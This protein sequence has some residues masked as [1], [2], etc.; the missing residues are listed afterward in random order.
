MNLVLTRLIGSFDKW[1]LSFAVFVVVY[2]LFLL[3]GSFDM[4]DVAHMS[5]Q[6]DE[7]N[8]L[9][10]GALLLQ[11]DFQQYLELNCFYPPVFDLFTA[12]F[13]GIGGVSVFSGRLVS[14]V[15]SILSL[16]AVFE[17]VYRLY[18]PKTAFLSSIILSAMPGYVLLSRMAMIET[19]LVF[20]FT[21]SVM[22]FLFWLKKQKNKFLV[23]S[24]IFFMIGIFTKYQTIIVVAIVIVSLVILGRSHIKR[25]LF[26]S[27]LVIAI[28][29][30]AI[31]L[32]LTI[33][34]LYSSGML[35]QWLY[36]LNIGN[37]DKSIYSTGIIRF[38]LWFD[39]LP[40]WLQT[41][42]FYLI[43]TTQPYSSTYSP[44]QILP[45]PIT[46][47][48]YIL[49]LVGLC[50]LSLRRKLEDK[51][52]IIW[53]FVVYVFFTFIPNREWRYVIPFF[54]VL[55]ISAANLV[56]SA[57]GKAQKIWKTP[58]LGI[59][60]KCLVQVIAGFLIIFTFVAIYDSY[61]NAYNWV[62]NTQIQ[63]PLEDT[64]SYIASRLN[65]G[66]NVMVLCAFNL[67]SL[68]I[69]R[70]YLCNQQLVEASVF[71]YPIEPVDTFPPNFDITQ[72]IDMCMEYNV[73]YLIVNE[74]GQ[75]STHPENSYHYYGTTTTFN[76]FNQTLMNSG[77]F[78]YESV[79]FWEEPARIFI[80][81]FT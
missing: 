59:G 19:T 5:I 38:G 78:T 62:V 23:L 18:G 67:I 70:F 32:I 25:V 58:R 77:R 17:F 71:Q 66:E 57:V 20:F 53:F 61:S 9:T 41:P 14:V 28:I 48:I 63:V 81:T 22:F 74:Y 50:C 42:L 43:E 39:S 36:A 64:T 40:S 21:V 69:V 1:K 3:F 12:C 6:W 79:Y 15:F 26:S 56:T 76:D 72:L 30:V 51:Y 10:G 34:W 49:G 4:L 80:L 47:P 60:K 7:V 46:L 73:K 35:N 65:P 55:A 29:A 27:R 16:F 11:G 33:Y 68:D 37:P 44:T 54:P 52:L 2:A 13:F 8:H 75:N 31:P 45:H 24:I